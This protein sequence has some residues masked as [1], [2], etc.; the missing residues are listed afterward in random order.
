MKR[1][2]NLYKNI[3]DINN[4]VS[5]FNEVCRNTSNKRKVAILKQYKCIYIS[6]IHQTL[7]NK[8]YV[9]APSNVF[10]IYEPK[11]RRI[12]SQPMEDKII[13][14]LVSREILYPAIIPCLLDVNVASRKNL[15]TKAGLAL[16][17]EFHRK[18]KIKYS[19]YYIL[20]CD[21]SKF[22]ASIDHSILKEKLRRK[23]KDPDALNI[24]YTIIDSEESGLGIG[25]MTSQT[26]A[27][28]YLNDLDHFIKETLKIKYYVRY[29]DDFLLFHPSKK[30]LNYCFEEIKKFLKKE[31]LT[32]NSKSR[33]YSSSNNFIFLGCNSKGKY[34]KYRSVNRKIK[35][36]MYLYKTGKISLNSLTSSIICYKHLCPNNLKIINKK[37]DFRL[38]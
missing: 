14:H 4:I 9:P 15:G 13:N 29:Q 2:N 37:E 31:N 7:L 27:I 22:F 12:I 38:P 1:K 32:L 8:Q 19:K 24:L 18:C 25:A 21:I 23:I 33:I 26:L 3:C 34:A 10:T 30:Y 20:K 36:K 28:F 16:A 11:E 5:A 35:S 17:Q 6:R